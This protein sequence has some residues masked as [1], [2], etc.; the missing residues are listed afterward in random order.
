MIRREPTIDIRVII[1]DEIVPDEP[2]CQSGLA[3]SYPQKTP[4]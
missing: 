4:E 3:H 2:G 1:L